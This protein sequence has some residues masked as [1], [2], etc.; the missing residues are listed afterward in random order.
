MNIIKL[1][2]LCYQPNLD[3][4]NRNFIN[5]KIMITDRSLN[6]RYFFHLYKFQYIF[7]SNY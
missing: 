7:N 5:L 4:R 3:Y 6:D 1:I 2:K